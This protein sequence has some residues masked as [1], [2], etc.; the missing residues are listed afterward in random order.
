M[1]C[2]SALIL[3]G[4]GTDRTR[5]FQTSK[6][7]CRYGEGGGSSLLLRTQGTT[8]V[9]FS[10]KFPIEIRQMTEL[11]R[12]KICPSTKAAALIRGRQNPADLRLSLSAL[13]AFVSRRRR[14]GYSFDLCCRRIGMAGLGDAPLSTNV[15]SC[16]LLH[17]EAP[18]LRKY[19]T[20]SISSPRTCYRPKVEL[21][22][23]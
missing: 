4:F 15:T 23:R 5:Q 18:L 14:I 8:G 12:R 6:R 7:T 1:R 10:E 11:A 21:A 9:R 22:S 3:Q 13:R 17:Y 16:S 19:R 2:K 20:R